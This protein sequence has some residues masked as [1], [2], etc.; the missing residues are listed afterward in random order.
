MRISELAD[1]TD[2]PVASIKY[3]VREGLLWPGERVGHNQTA[4]TDA[5]ADRLRL[6]RA[7]LEVGRLSIAS[8]KQVIAAIDEPE[9]ELLEVLGIAQQSLP[10]APSRPTPESLGRVEALAT[11]RGWTSFCT[12]TPN[13]GL[14]LAA[15]ALDG[16]H[17]SGLENVQPLLGSFAEAAETAARADVDFVLSTTNRDDQIRTVAVGIP[18]GDALFAG[19]RRMAQESESA[20]RLETAPTTQESE[21]ARGLGA[22]PTTPGST[23]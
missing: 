11:E 15:A 17:A 4:Y 1:V 3:Y 23:P 10:A 16:M 9:L 19:L 22:G 13:P 7:L 14:A 2:V 6:V 5:H 18:L 20:R 21:L 12:P 8:A